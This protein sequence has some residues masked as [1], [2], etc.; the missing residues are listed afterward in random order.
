MQVISQMFE[1][2]AGF[3]TG[4]SRAHGEIFKLDLKGERNKTRL[5]REKLG[6]ITPVVEK[7]YPSKVL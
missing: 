4:V 7:Q 6:S 5:I 1:E 2:L 3:C